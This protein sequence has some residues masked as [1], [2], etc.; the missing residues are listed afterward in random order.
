VSFIA[1]APYDHYDA[2]PEAVRDSGAQVM[3]TVGHVQELDD[4]IFAFHQLAQ[5]AVADA[6]LGPMQ[7]AP[8]PVRQR[9]QS[10]IQAALVGGGAVNFFGNAIADFNAGVDRLNARWLLGVLT[11]FFVGAPDY[12]GARNAADRAEIESQHAESVSTAR[13]QLR[14]ELDAVYAQLEA[15]L[16]EMAQQAAGMLDAGP[17][18]SVVLRLFQAGALPITSPAAFPEVDFGRID[19]AALLATLER[20]GLLTAWMTVPAEGSLDLANRLEMLRAMGVAPQE[21]RTLLQQFWVSVAAERAGID[22][23]AWDPM[24]GADALRGIIQGA[25]TYYG[26]LFLEHPELQWAG[27]A[28]MIGPSFAGGFFDLA[29]LRRL[30]DA[31][32]G[33]IDD[34]PLGAGA[35]LPL[36]LQGLGLVSNMT[37]EEIRFYESQFLSMQREIF[38]DQAMM[39]EAYLGGGLPALE[40]L[41]DAGLIDDATLRAW[42]Q[43]DTGARTGDQ[44]LVA[45]GNTHL[46]YR[47][48]HDIIRDDY[49]R[50]YSHFPSGPAVTYLL[51]AVGAPSIPGAQSLGDVRPLEVR[52]PVNHSPFGWLV[53][54][55]YVE[56]STP[57][58]NGNIADFGTRWALIEQDTLPA[59]QELLRENPE[60]ARDIVASPVHDRI[61]LQRLANRIDDI[62]IDLTTDWDVRIDW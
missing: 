59:Y 22:L 6:L 37:E 43:I 15:E 27:M 41:R 19:H 55:T 57:L 35:L 13:S 39:H 58:P 18:E 50:M 51:G 2:S 16:N 56:V 53:H 7:A 1:S 30:A 32:G 46:L 34:L 42:E 60:L 62:I 23:D 25:Y 45:A 31:L 20:Y 12:S 24:L 9:A 29:M 21:Y 52:V 26:S 48:Q 4:S 5:A 8:E 10:V 3:L 28:N 49:D 11:N 33:P 47:E 17:T 36:P 40:E 14:S 54:Q 38:F 44:D 61:E